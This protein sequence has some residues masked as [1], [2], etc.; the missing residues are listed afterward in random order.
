[1]YEEEEE[2]PKGAFAAAKNEGNPE[3][4]SKGFLFTCKH[5]LTT[6]PA[7]NKQQLCTFAVETRGDKERRSSRTILGTC[8]D[9]SGDWFAKSF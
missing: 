2:S 1:M 5:Y 8:K 6:L 4:P 9:V 7:L 3:P